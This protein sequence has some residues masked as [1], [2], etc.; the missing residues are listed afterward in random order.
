MLRILAF[1]CLLLTPMLAASQ[2]L[3]DLTQQ[4]TSSGLKDAL[5]Q[6]ANSA[7][8]QL[9]RPGGFSNDSQRRISL[10]GHLGTAARTMKMMGM[11]AQVTQLENSM[12]LAA[13]AAVPNAQALLVQAIQNMTLSDA[14]SILSGPQD[15]ATRYLDSSSRPALRT[16]LLPVVSEAT[17]QV[18]LA[19]QYNQFAGQAARYGAIQSQ[20][21]SIESYVTE[22]A[23]NGLFAIMA[24]QEAEI[25]NNPAAAAT[26]LAKKV[27]GAR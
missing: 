11:G 3:S 25:R 27:F 26:S 9:G 6:A 24:E 20:D 23:L 14:R 12:N 21:A 18:G 7:V 16:A 1:A 5:V 10:P 15:S 4:E 8:Q 17:A 22:Q 19:Q 13:E 2:T